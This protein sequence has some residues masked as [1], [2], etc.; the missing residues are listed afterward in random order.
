V[1]AQALTCASTFLL[2]RFLFL[3]E[4]RLKGARSFTLEA[5][6]GTRLVKDD[7]HSLREPPVC[8]A[9]DGFGRVPARE[10]GSIDRKTD[11]DF[12]Y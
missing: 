4:R 10:R 7:A 12:I 8:S 9:G 1:L 2:V 11:T 3:P 6:E 5:G